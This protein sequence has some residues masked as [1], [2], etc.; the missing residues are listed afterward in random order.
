ME[1]RT[2]STLVS[3]SDVDVT[4]NAVFCNILGFRRGTT[5]TRGVIV[6]HGQ[7]GTLGRGKVWVTWK[8]TTELYMFP[9]TR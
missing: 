9:P 4:C 5:V 8:G 7:G 3:A 1:I 6:D 2:C